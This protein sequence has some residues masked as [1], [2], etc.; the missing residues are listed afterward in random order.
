MCLTYQN[1]LYYN[2]SLLSVV[3]VFY[4]DEH[5]FQMI[6]P[7]SCSGVSRARASKS[8]EA[9]EGRSRKISRAAEKKRG[10]KILMI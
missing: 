3:F 4:F 8:T 5:K 9:W 1:L 2:A 7:I 6:L 10:K